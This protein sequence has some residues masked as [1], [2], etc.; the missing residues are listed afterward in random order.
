MKIKESLPFLRPPNQGRLGLTLA[1]LLIFI[2]RIPDVVQ[3]PQFWAE[4]GRI[5][6]RQNLCDG[7]AAIGKAYAGYLH[8]VPRIVALVAGAFRP[9]HVPA[10]YIA[11]ALILT[12][13]VLYLVQS[14][15]LALPLAPLLALAIVLSPAGLEAYGNLTNVQWFLSLGVLALVLMQPPQSKVGIILEGAFV[16][17]A[18]LTGPFVVLLLPVFGVRLLLNWKNQP[19]RNRML[20]LTAAAAITSLAQ[21]YA[22][23]NNPGVSGKQDSPRVAAVEVPLDAAAA[24]CTH[25]LGPL[26]QKIGGSPAVETEVLIG[27]LEVGFLLFVVMRA[28][29]EPQLRFERLSLVYFGSAVLVAALYKFRDYPPTLIPPANGPRYFLIPTIIAG[30]LLISAVKEPRVGL[31]AKI[32]LGLFLVSGLVGFRRDPFTDYSWPFWAHSLEAGARPQIPT[33]PPGW[34]VVTDCRLAQPQ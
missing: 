17:M 4:D 33:N 21:V 20:V 14:P 30:W 3:N 11:A 23:R 6:F 7:P 26:L 31:L 2:L 28:M 10:F 24:I 16:A 34:F 5:F 12:G 27:L 25:T 18:G 29:K 8:L 22:L 15:R 1:F 32:L 19:G 9:T 13:V